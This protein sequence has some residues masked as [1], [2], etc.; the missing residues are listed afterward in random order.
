MSEPDL[1]ITIPFY[2]EE[3]GCELVLR[4]L[5][6]A[7]DKHSVAYEILAVD[8]GSTDQ[9]GRILDQIA[10]SSPGVQVVKVARNEGYGWG[11]ISGLN[12]STGEYIGYIDGDTQV[13]P[14]EVM[15]VYQSV[16]ISKADIGKGKRIERFD[17]IQRKIISKIYNRLFHIIF[18]CPIPDINAKPKILRRAIYEQLDLTSRDWFIDAEIMLKAHAAGMH[19]D[20]VEIEF[21]KRQEGIS[22]V[23]FSTIWEFIKNLWNYRVHGR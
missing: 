4:N 19:I 22:K 7:L 20:E 5:T 21:L 13:S 8:N 1:S 17:G 3:A 16:L 10:Q 18:A 6:A 23:R 11:V 9:T 2:N 15:R 14:D 12:S